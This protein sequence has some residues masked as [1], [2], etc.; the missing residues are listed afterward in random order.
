[1][2][3]T[4]MFLWQLAIIA[5]AMPTFGS[6]LVKKVSCML[7]PPAKKIQ[8]R[9]IITTAEKFVIAKLYIRP[10]SVNEFR[11]M[12]EALAVQT[13]KEPGCIEYTWY[14]EP[15]EAGAFMLIEHYRNQAGLQYHFRQPY[16]SE[17]VKK[18]EGWKSKDWIVYFL[19]S[20]PDALK[21]DK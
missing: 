16:L 15:G 5:L 4:R 11:Q 12:L 10:A 18:M 20:E 7:P 19:S 6:P 9:S 8:R 3:R 2:N 14:P 21:E 1:M 13:R 17:F